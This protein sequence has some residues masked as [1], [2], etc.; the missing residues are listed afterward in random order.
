MS[1]IKTKFLTN[2]AVTNAKLAQMAAHTFKG[3]NTGSTANALDL[4]AIQLSNELIIPAQVISST[5]IDWATGNLFTQ[6]L[7]AHTTFT[8]SNN[9]SGQTIVVRLTNTGSNYTVTW[10]TVKW[11]NG[12]PPTMTVG[13][14][15]DIYTFIY[16]GSDIYGSAVQN[17]S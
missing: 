17:M 2:N 14:F 12:T 13:A 7:G 10:P 5:A 3:N 1:Q 6:T 11:S 15:S 9:V 4:T 8:F 16:D